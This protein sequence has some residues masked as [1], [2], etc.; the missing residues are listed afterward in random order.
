MSPVGFEPTISAGERP[1]T[2]ALD[3][4]ATGTG[5][6]HKYTLKFVCLVYLIQSDPPSSVSQHTCHM[7]RSCTKHRQRCMIQT[8]NTHINLNSIDC[9]VIKCIDAAYESAPNII[10]K[11][12]LQIYHEKTAQVYNFF[13]SSNIF[14][15]CYIIRHSISA[16]ERSHKF[17][18][19][20]YFKILVQQTLILSPW[21]DPISTVW[22]PKLQKKE[23]PPKIFSYRKQLFPSWARLADGTAV[24]SSSE[25]P[26]VS[27]KLTILNS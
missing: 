10:R 2:Y 24:L 13:F 6:C 5:R 8:C 15:A 26:T 19:E 21:F 27:A 9:L 18:V 1:Q 16:P 20:S 14:P 7:N 22:Q 23:R 11:V 25:T 17:D 3:R 12:R 4:T